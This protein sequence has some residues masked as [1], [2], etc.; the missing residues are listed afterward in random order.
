MK[1]PKLLVPFAKFDILFCIQKKLVYQEL[2][3]WKE[4]N[5]VPVGLNNSDRWSLQDI[6]KRNPKNW[7][8]K[9]HEICFAFYFHCISAAT[10]S[11]WNTSLIGT[12]RTITWEVSSLRNKISAFQNNA[13][14]KLDCHISREF[15]KIILFWQCKPAQFPK[16]SCPIQLSIWYFVSWASSSSYGSSH[17]RCSIKKIFFKNFRKIY[18]K[19]L[20]QSLLF[21]CRPAILFKKTLTQMFFCEICKMFKNIFFYITPPGATS[22]STLTVDQKLA[23]TYPAIK[24]LLPL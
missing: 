10:F 6:L 19:G 12:V 13:D 4:L 23:L 22:S 3:I 9:C 24:V 2:L 20:C 1:T 7:L 14:I 15:Q 21:F 5:C 11:G 16:V 8:K 17:R 18:W